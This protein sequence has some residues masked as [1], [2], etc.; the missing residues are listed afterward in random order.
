[1]IILRRGALPAGEVRAGKP[2]ELTRN[3]HRMRL[4]K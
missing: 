2:P 1:M 3:R 4:S